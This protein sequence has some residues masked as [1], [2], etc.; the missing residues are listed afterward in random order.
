MLLSHIT[1]LVILLLCEAAES[2][3]ARGSKEDELFLMCDHDSDGKISVTELRK[4]ANFPKAK[5]DVAKEVFRVF[6]EDQSGFLSTSEYFKF[7]SM[8]FEAVPRAE[9]E[10]GETPEEVEVIDRRGKKKVMKKRD[11]DQMNQDKMKGLSMEEGEMTK[12][13]RE[14]G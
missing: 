7:V 1:V 2:E 5:G 9:E 3:S 12:V 6:D 14:T 4:C 13:S 11:F 10:E 8:A